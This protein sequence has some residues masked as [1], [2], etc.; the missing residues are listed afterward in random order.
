MKSLSLLALA[1]FV[2]TAALARVVDHQQ[3]AFDNTIVE[4]PAE[5]FL[6]QL[7]PDE[8]RWVTEEEKWAL[9]R[10]W[11]GAQDP[12]LPAVHGH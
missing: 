6:I 4:K 5:K 12:F 7:G 11:Q 1:A 10:V 3:V 9:K 8:K 2:P